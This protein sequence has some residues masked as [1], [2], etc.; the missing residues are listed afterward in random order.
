MSFSYSSASQLPRRFASSLPLVCTS[1]A[2]PATTRPNELLSRPQPIAN[3]RTRPVEGAK[4]AVQE[5]LE[6]Y[7]TNVESAIERLKTLDGAS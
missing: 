4:P 1:R 3:R 7:L 5:A 6:R 2:T